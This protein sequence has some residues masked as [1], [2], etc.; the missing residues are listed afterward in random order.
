VSI[1]TFGAVCAEV[2][3]DVTSGRITVRRDVVAP[4]CGRL[5]NPLLARSQVI[6]GVTQGLGYALSEHDIVDHELGIVLN[7]NLEDYLVPTMADSCEIVHAEVDAPDHAANPIGTKG[8][9][10]LPMIAVAPAIANAVHD[11]TGVR[12]RDLPITRRRLLDALGER[13][14]R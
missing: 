14:A 10:E 7:A 13:E 2:H 4:D 5:V 3:V 12:I 11:A 9:G 6:G 1:R 8:L